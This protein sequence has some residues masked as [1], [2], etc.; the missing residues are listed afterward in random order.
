MSR[1]I[2]ILFA[3]F[4]F[5][6]AHAAGILVWG[7]SLSAGYG[8]A[9]DK[10]WPTLLAARL[11]AEGYKHV[12]TNASISGE[13]TAGGLARLPEALG[14]VK[15]SIVIIEL[16]ANDGLRGLPVKAMQA[17]LDAMIQLA[18]RANAKVLLIGMRMPPNFGPMYTQKFQQVYADLAAR[19]KTA[20]VPFMMEGFA[21]RSELF[22][23]DRLHPGIEAQ[24]LVLANVWPALQPL[25]GKR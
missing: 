15:P 3:L 16:G 7:D 14:R 13:T 21:S 22:Q 17:N 4:S 18:S 5:Q 20:L 25:L 12:L 23:N 10:A 11:S 2:V 1:F 9:Q 19:H 8:I 6:S 24:P